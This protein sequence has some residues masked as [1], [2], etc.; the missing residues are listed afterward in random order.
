MVS[1][2][3]AMALIL[4]C[5]KML[6]KCSRRIDGGE[7]AWHS[8]QMTSDRQRFLDGCEQADCHASRTQTSSSSNSIIGMIPPTVGSPLLVQGITMAV[9]RRN[10][11][12]APATVHQTR[13]IA[14]SLVGNRA[15]RR[16]CAGKL[17]LPKNRHA[18]AKLRR[19]AQRLSLSR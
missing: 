18:L 17:H 9:P 1:D 11:S 19:V 7:A 6:L 16:C 12:A 14:G 3:G 10:Q 5:W 4:T 2:R 15:A 8:L 13:V